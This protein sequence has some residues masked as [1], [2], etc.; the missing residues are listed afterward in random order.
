M[1]VGETP[2]KA[3]ALMAEINSLGHGGTCVTVCTRMHACMSAC[4]RPH[5]VGVG[6]HAPTLP[7]LQRALKRGEPDMPAI[8]KLNSMLNATRRSERLRS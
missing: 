2:D 4:V 3:Q 5:G 7:A 6:G 1:H 8:L